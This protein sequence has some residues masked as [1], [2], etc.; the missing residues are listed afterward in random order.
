[1]K[2]LLA[3]ASLIFALALSVAAQTV[4][5]PGEYMVPAC[6]PT[7]TA[8]SLPTA[9]PTSTTDPTAFTTI[10]M[11]VPAS[12][13]TVYNP[14]GPFGPQQSGAQFT[15]DN[16]RVAAVNVYIDGAHVPNVVGGIVNPNGIA[17]TALFRLGSQPI[18]GVSPTYSLM[19][20][21]DGS[22]ATT[23]Y[24]RMPPSAYVTAG[25]H[26]F[27]FLAYNDVGAVINTQVRTVTVG[28]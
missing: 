6:V 17:W 1:M 22:I 4:L 27:Q 11:L 3:V 9:T 2:T 20:N 7:A 24:G 14:S 23:Q 18:P 15:V 5:P 8:T 25:V 19:W 13:L 21:M 26:T 12:G 10:N 16:T 28:P